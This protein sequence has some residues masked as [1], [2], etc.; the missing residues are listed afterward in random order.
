MSFAKTTVYLDKRAIKRDGTYP[1]KIRI[2]YDRK[3][4]YY[5]TN[6]S[7]TEEDFNRI[8]FTAKRLSEDDKVI[9]RCIHDF[10]NKAIQII[11]DLPLFTWL[12]F[13]KKFISNRAAKFSVSD[14]IMEY[15]IELRKEGRIGTAFSYECTKSS[16]DKFLPAATFIDITPKVLRDY[17]LQMVQKGRSITTVGIYLRSLRSIFNIAIANGDLKKDYYPFGS[18]KKGKY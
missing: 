11:K 4:K 12:S 13:E 17:E 5:L 18:I 7:L 3:Q 6:H 1:I 16:F 10:E 15:A 14:A 2:T 8:L 9:K